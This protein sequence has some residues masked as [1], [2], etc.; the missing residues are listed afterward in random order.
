MLHLRPTEHR[1][2]HRL[3]GVM[4]LA[5]KIRL[6]LALRTIP[7]VSN[8]AGVRVRARVLDVQPRLPVRERLP[9]LAEGIHFIDGDHHADRLLRGALRWTGDSEFDEAEAAGFHLGAKLI[10][11]A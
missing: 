10:H 3:T 11:E 6:E 2:G 4:T 7:V 1:D 5:R 9:V 8:L